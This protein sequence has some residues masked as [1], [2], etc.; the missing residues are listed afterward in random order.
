MNLEG[1]T[2]YTVTEYLN[3]KI[4]GSKIYKITMPTPLSLVLFLRQGA[5]TFTLLANCNSA[6]PALWLTDTM[7]ETPAEPPAFCMLLRKHLE[8]GRI[9]RIKQYGLD[10][11]IE[12]EISLLGRSSRIITKQLI[13]ELTGKNANLIFT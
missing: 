9:T 8:E 2:L 7:P 1:I 4:S 3:R 6:A 12:L 10:R 11:V 5:E 13:V